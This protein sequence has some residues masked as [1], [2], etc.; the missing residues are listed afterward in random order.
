MT[1]E[2]NTAA[3]VVGTNGFVWYAEHIGETD[4]HLF[5]SN[6]KIIRN[7]GTTKGLAQLVDGPTSATVCDVA[8]DVVLNRQ[9]FVF[10]IPCKTW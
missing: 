1:N 9:A 5:L 4:S 2:L 8:S 3:I 6:A 10:L 7:W